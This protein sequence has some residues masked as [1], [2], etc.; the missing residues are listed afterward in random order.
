MVVN[1]NFGAVTIIVVAI[2]VAAVAYYRYDC[3]IYVINSVIN[4]D[5]IHF[6]L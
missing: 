6:T 4:S 1:G 5:K 3:L 2:F